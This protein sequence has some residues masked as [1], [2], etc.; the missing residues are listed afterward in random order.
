M[1]EEG[2]SPLWH[3]L[4]IDDA[5]QALESSWDGL[6]G[7]EAGRRLGRSG[8]N[9]LTAEEGTGPLR[10]LARQFKNPLIYLLAGAALLSVLVDHP[11]DA[12]VISGVIVLNALLG[13]TQEWRAEGALAALKSMAAPRALSLIHI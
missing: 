6:G 10:M 12:V 4:D 7:D 1:T 2:G 11:V 5:L 13:F 8:T 9:A 3:V